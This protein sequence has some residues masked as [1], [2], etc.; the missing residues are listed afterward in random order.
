[1]PKYKSIKKKNH[2]KTLKYARK[3]KRKNTNKNNYCGGMPIRMWFNGSRAQSRLRPEVPLPPSNTPD[4]DD[5]QMRRHADMTA[6]YALINQ[7]E[8]EHAQQNAPAIAAIRER[9]LQQAN[10]EALERAE[11]E[12]LERAD[13]EALERAEEALAR[14]ESRFMQ[15][16][17]ATKSTTPHSANTRK[18][19]NSSRDHT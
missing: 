8:R 13:A 14:R 4:Y 17:K 1:M 5:P 6:M 12:A 18:T 7:L 10:A 16:F 11:T 3:N 15:P 19:M 9:R 2:Y